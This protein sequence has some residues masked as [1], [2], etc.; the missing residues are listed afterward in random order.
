MSDLIERLRTG[1]DGRTAE[2]DC[3]AADEIEQLRTE[4]ERIVKESKQAHS[5]NDE[6][7]AERFQFKAEIERLTHNLRIAKANYA[8]AEAEIERLRAALRRIVVENLDEYCEEI[9]LAALENDDE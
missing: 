9:A 3:E 4:N 8:G 2:L 6:L 1:C 7:V 5:R